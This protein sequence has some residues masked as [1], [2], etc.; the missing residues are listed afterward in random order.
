MT[1][2]VD[3]LIDELEQCCLGGKK[4]PTGKSFKQQSSRKQDVIND[5][6][7]DILTELSSSSF[8]MENS[9]IAP[10]TTTRNFP[11]IKM[12]KRNISSAPADN[13]RCW[14]IYLSPPRSV[15]E[16]R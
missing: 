6:I 4:Q 12:P 10:G 1:G 14:P 5:E 9:N 15:T 8:E 11:D 7:E 2:D 16:D 13:R 3:F